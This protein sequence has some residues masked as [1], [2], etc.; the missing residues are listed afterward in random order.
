MSTLSA[1]YLLIAWGEVWDLFNE[2]GLYV[3]DVDA[4]ELTTLDGGE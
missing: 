1:R 2:V 4:V 3:G